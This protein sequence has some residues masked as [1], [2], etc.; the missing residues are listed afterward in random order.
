[1]EFLHNPTYN[2]TPK[3]ITPNADNG[4]KRNTLVLRPI[5][6]LKLMHIKLSQF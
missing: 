3:I 6:K 4:I 1:M 2:I 5:V